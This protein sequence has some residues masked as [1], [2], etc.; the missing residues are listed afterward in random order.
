MH[1]ILN[2]ISNKGLL[3]ECDKEENLKV[4]VAAATSH[5]KRITLQLYRHVM[6]CISY[7][8]VTFILKIVTE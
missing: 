3:E 8:Y 2:C 4:T 5:L 7:T 1:N 6:F